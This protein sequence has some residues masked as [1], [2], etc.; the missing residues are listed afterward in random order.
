MMSFAGK[1]ELESQENYEQFLEAVGHLHAKTDLKVQTEVH[2]E[3]KDFTWTQSLP[4]WT[5]SNK[6]TI[7]QECELVTM[8]GSKFKA[9]VIMENGKI[10]VQFP[11]YNFTAEMVHD[12]LVMICITPG[13]K[14]VTFTRVSKRI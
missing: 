2:Q 6:F 12:K 13:E 7:G 4:G 5:W 14:G 11:Q 3:G 9:P 8:T 1:Y 10:S